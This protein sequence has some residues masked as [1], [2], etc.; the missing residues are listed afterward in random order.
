VLAPDD[1]RRMLVQF[2]PSTSYEDFFEGYRPRLGADGT[3]AY[4]LQRGPLRLL[5]DRAAQSPSTHVQ[6]IDEIN[7]ANLPKVFGELLFLLEYRD[8]E[9]F[10]TYRPDEPFTLPPNLWFIGTMNTADR[11]I[12]LIDA[13]LRRRFHFVPFFPHEGPMAGLLD[14]WLKEHVPSMR[15]VAGVVDAVTAE[16]VDELGGPHLQIGPSHIM[17]DKLDDVLLRRIWDF[18]VFPYI[19]DQLFG[20]PAKIE[21]FRLD[22]VL[23]RHRAAA[24]VDAD[25]DDAVEIETEAA[26]VG[27]VGG[28]DE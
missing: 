15:W 23:A 24:Q 25:I 6:L 12:A 8:H 1:S 11:S 17:K 18:D 7:R 22:R 2:H 4:D 14:R 13:A 27:G 9:V 21:H 26:D 16:L 5:A 10:T 3:L 19:E 20:E 28:V